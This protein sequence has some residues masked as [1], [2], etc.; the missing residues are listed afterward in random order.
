M[1]NPA[2][3]TRPLVLAVGLDMTLV[4]TDGTVIPLPAGH[5]WELPTWC[6][7]CSADLVIASPEG[8]PVIVPFSI[9]VVEDPTTGTPALRLVCAGHEDEDDEDGRD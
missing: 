7:Y 4:T 8:H 6:G 2:E 1:L 5:R 3:S 9:T